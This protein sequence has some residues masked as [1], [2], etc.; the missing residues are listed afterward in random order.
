GNRPVWSSQAE[1]RGEDGYS[2]ARERDALRGNHWVG[3]T[4]PLPLQLGPRAG[5]GERDGASVGG[6]V[7]LC[8][9]VRVGG[10]PAVLR[11]EHAVHELL[12]FGAPGL[13]G[14]RSAVDG[15]RVGEHRPGA[16]DRAGG[17]ELEGFV[18]GR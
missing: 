2:Q 3:V 18:L 4:V 1:H 9:G 15:S 8:L 13:W 6:G 16:V 5:G 14:D 7:A 17:G 10:G 11:T 12:A